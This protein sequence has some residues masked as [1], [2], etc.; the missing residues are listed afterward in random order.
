M[1]PQTITAHMAEL[2]RQMKKVLKTERFDHT[3][4]VAYTAASLAFLY[5][6]DTDQAL[7]AGMLHDCA[8]YVEH[9]VEKCRKYKIPVTEAEEKEPS[10][11]HA[12][13]GAYL[14]E[15]QYHVND[16]EVLNAIR[17]HTTGHPDMT[18]LEK[19]IFVADYIE[20]NRKMLP[21]LPEIRKMAYHN[22][23]EAIVSILQDTLA[24][25]EQSGKTTDPETQ[26]T[27]C[28]YL[29]RKSV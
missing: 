21:H 8:K 13:L 19:I 10:L 3:L 12:K 5:D 2:R 1:E 22:L 15:H 17:Y 26:K 16:Q 20:P 7:T 11:L 18:R 29:S 4:G 25:L 14:A 27:L 28:F 23:D 6:V 24:Y 9:K